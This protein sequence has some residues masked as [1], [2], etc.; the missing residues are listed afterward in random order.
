MFGWVSPLPLVFEDFSYIG[1][2]I[3]S[4]SSIS[5][6][7]FLSRLGL[8]VMLLVSTLLWPGVLSRSISVAG[9]TW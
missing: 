1:S 8:G 5:M 4:L 9:G 6:G 7:R 3:V 2:S